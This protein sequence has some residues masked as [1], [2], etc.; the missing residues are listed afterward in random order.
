MGKTIDVKK[1]QYLCEK[2][3]MS[4]KMSVGKTIDVI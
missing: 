3:M 1:K 4:Y 2:P